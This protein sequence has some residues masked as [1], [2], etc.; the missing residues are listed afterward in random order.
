MRNKRNCLYWVKCAKK[1]IYGWFVRPTIPNI[2]PL[3]A[4]RAWFFSCCKMTACVCTVI[5]Q[6]CVSL[7]CCSFNSPFESWVALGAAACTMLAAVIHPVWLLGTMFELTGLKFFIAFTEAANTS[8]KAWLE[9]TYFKCNNNSHRW[10]LFFSCSSLYCLFASLC[11]AVM[12]CIRKIQCWSHARRSCSI[13][14]M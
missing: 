9:Q 11:T 14:C 10:F 1:S 13:W 2:I 8:E 12:R 5:T 4:S 6:K 7:S 3:W